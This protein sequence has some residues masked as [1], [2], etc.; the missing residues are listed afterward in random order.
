MTTRYVKPSS[1]TSMTFAPGDQVIR[2]V[3][4]QPYFCTVV[5]VE[6]DEQVRVSCNLW[7]SGYSALVKP[8]DVA[9]VSRGGMSADF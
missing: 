6:Q 5:Q 2:Y 1:K 9:L 7:P 8:Q 4:G 3:N